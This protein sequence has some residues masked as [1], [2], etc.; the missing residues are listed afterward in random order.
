M[1]F[2]TRTGIEALI[3]GKHT[4]NYT[5]VTLILLTLAV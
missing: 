5:T 2:S 3:K 4:F 1:L